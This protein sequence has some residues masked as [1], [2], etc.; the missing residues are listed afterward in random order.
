MQSISD[1]TEGAEG[2]GEEEEDHRATNLLKFVC[3]FFSSIEAAATTAA[4]AAEFK[5]GHFLKDNIP[6]CSAR[7]S[8]LSTYWL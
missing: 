8:L 6:C 7:L 4:A 1:S 2:Q 5:R 3:V